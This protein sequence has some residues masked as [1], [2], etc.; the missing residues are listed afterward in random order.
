MASNL[1]ANLYKGAYSLFNSPMLLDG[2]IVAQAIKDQVQKEIIA[3]K[4][5]KKQ[6]P[7]LAV[8]LIGNDPASEVY[9]GH[10]IKACQEIGIKSFQHRLPQD[11]SEKK[12]LDLIQ[13]LNQDSKVH[14]ILVQ[15]PVPK[16]ID[17]AKVL[18]ALEP[19]K[20]VDGLAPANIGLGWSGRPRVLPCTPA[21]IIEILKYYKIPMVKKNAVVVGRSDIVGKPMAQLFLKED[22]TVTIC[23]SQTQKL[24]EITSAADIVV[25]AVGKKQFFTKDYFAKEAVVI[26]V[27]I[28]R[29]ENGKLCGD[30]CFDEVK[31]HVRAI[32]PV[33]GG[34]GPMTIAMLVKNTF[35]LYKLQNK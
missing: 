12:V 9:V 11:T 18:D 3:L 15:M 21:G 19:M 10:K 28:H 20:D 6:F 16:H 22:A 1:K 30:A 32:T 29:L 35:E 13:T 14:G 34:V 24:K 27:G 8:V 17:Y 31:D 7:G 26:D 25:L 4:D 5:H 33:P 23:H 2:K